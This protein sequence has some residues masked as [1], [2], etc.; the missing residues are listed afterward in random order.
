M[1][2]QNANKDLDPL[3]RIKTHKHFQNSIAISL[4]F[5]NTELGLGVLVQYEYETWRLH[6]QRQLLLV[7]HPFQPLMA[8]PEAW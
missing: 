5:W 6:R 3:Q 1:A 2:K 8:S 4:L 7:I